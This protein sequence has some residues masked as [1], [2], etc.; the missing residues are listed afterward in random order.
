MSVVNDDV[1]TMKFDALAS[2][3]DNQRGLPHHAVSAWMELV[4]HLARRSSME[5]VEPG[6]G[7]GRIALPVA[8]LGHQ[9]TGADISSPML[10]ACAAA[11]DDLV[12]GDHVAL[13][14]ADATDLPLADQ[15]FDMGIVAQLLYLI[16]DWPTVLD[17]LARLVK[18]GG[19]VIH[20]TEP[21]TEGDALQQWSAKWRE[22]IEATGYRHLELSPVDED[23]RA[24]FLRRWPDVE[25]R[26]LASWSFGQ[27][28][29]AAMTDYAT[30]LRPLY[31]PV[32]ES[33]WLA[34]TEEFLAWAREEF[35]NEETLLE[36]TVTLTAMIASV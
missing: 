27:S 20:V 17:E 24:E 35:P 12:I 31:L 30:R 4:D 28:V 14:K 19:F 25:T 1:V 34:A 7:T 6:I 22:I 15:S 36:G 29:A 23:V 3:F 11:A 13:L 9:V 32:P 2:E 33:D 8:L 16:D 26:E 21:T 5:I 18:P 10:N